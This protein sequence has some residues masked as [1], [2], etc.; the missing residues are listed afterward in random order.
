[1]SFDFIRTQL[2]SQIYNQLMHLDIH[3]LTAILQFIQNTG[4]IS[5][6]LQLLEENQKI[7]KGV[8]N[9]FCSAYTA[10]TGKACPT[11]ICQTR[12]QQDC[13]PFHKY[14]SPPLK[15]QVR[16]EVYPSELMM[17]T[18]ET[19]KT[20]W[21]TPSTV[22]AARLMGTPQRPMIIGADVLEVSRKTIGGVKIEESLA[23]LRKKRKPK[24]IKKIM[25]LLTKGKYP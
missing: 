19:E 3:T 7:P 20:L 25:K 8:Y 18:P 13:V 22:K 4:S 1:M 2:L 9:L 21:Q 23:A 12:Y 24:I 6:I 15:P 11:T 16:S 5:P 17:L 10:K 14:K